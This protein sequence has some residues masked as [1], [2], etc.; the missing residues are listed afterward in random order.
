MYNGFRFDLTIFTAIPLS[1]CQ[2]V[3]RENINKNEKLEF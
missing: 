1:R 3:S 2:S